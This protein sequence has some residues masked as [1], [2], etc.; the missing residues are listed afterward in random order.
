[1]PKG[2]LASSKLLVEAFEFSTLPPPSSAKWLWKLWRICK[3]SQPC[4]D[5][6]K[7]GK[8][9]FPPLWVKLMGWCAIDQ[10]HLNI[11]DMSGGQNYVLLAMDMGKVSGPLSVVKVFTQI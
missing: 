7:G 4:R 8:T 6:V 10:R 2:I 11:V 1:V 5:G 3:E 9:C